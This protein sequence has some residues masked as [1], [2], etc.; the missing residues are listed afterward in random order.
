M[1]AAAGIS[2]G[3]NTKPVIL[4]GNAFRTRRFE[5]CTL[6]GKRT[7]ALHAFRGIVRSKRR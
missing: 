2:G 5:G 4:C 3:G 1:A 7:V 6:L